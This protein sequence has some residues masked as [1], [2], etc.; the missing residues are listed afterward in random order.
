MP[1][2]SGLEVDG[3]GGV[4]LLESLGSQRWAGSDEEVQSHIIPARD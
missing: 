2:E 1:N 4:L 3:W